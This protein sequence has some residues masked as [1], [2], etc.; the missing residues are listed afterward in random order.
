MTIVK[1]YK[2]ELKLNNQQRTLCL[3]SAGAARLMIGRIIDP[4]LLAAGVFGPDDDV[5]IG[6]EDPETGEP[7]DEDT[8]YVYV[9]TWG[10][11]NPIV[12]DGLTLDQVRIHGTVPDWRDWR[13]LLNT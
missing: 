9:Q 13:R 12:W 1:G 11:H 6:Y 10:T 3:K 4:D 2:T 8:G 7:T 5:E